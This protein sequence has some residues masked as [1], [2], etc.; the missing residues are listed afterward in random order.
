MTAPLLPLHV[1]VTRDRK[2]FEEIIEG[3]EQAWADFKMNEGWE[4]SGR[5]LTDAYLPVVK[6]FYGRGSVQD[7]TRA[8]V[9][10]ML[11]FEITHKVMQFVAYALLNYYDKGFFNKRD[12]T[13]LLTGMA[14]HFDTRQS[15]Y[16]AASFWVQQL[17]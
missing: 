17:F 8:F 9:N 2:S 11:P 16:R 13:E 5:K 12:A 1:A 7:A 4:Y 14:R 6:F 3:A 15:D 10:A